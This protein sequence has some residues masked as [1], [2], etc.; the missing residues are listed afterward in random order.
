MRTIYWYLNFALTLLATLPKLHKIKKLEQQGDMERHDALVYQFSKEW[1]MGNLKRAGCTVEVTGSI[2]LP[3]N[4]PFVIISNHQG[5][6]DI[7][8]LMTHLGRPVGFV[9]K[10]EAKKLP[11]IVKWMELMHCVFMDRSTLKGSAGAIIEGIKEIKK[12]YSL[13]LFPEGRRSKGR[14]MAEFKPA[15]F[16]L[17]TKA[18][19]PIIPVTIDGTY[20]L[21]EQNNNQ[22]RPATVKLTIHPSIETKGLSKEELALLPSQVKKIIEDSLT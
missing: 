17:A 18:G 21:M 6:F 15:S 4:Q 12:G 2:D 8:V 14:T 10:I 7:P 1:M 13:V 16:K 9:S 11:I 19:V 5:N 3:D 22:I 20:Q